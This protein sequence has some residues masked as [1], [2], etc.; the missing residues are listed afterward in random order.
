MS[1]GCVTDLSGYVLRS[2][3]NLFASLRELIFHI[4]GS[5]WNWSSIL[6]VLSGLISNVIVSP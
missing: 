4:I 2:V 6:L 1:Y 5:L 3:A